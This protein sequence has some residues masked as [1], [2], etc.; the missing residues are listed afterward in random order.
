MSKETKKTI[1]D[2]IKLLRD[3]PEYGRAFYEYFEDKRDELISAQFTRT[4]PGFDKKCH[5][6]AQFVQ[7]QILDEFKLKS[8]SRRD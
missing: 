6:S 1:A 7:N 2:V 3:N 5:I 4:D 8:L